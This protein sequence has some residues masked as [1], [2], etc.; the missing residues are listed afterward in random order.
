MTTALVERDATLP[1][2]PDAFVPSETLDALRGILPRRDELAACS[3]EALVSMGT[4][5]VE[6]EAR[7]RLILG[8]CAL[9]VGSR[10]GASA[11]QRKA[12]V[13]KFCLDLGGYPSRQ[14]AENVRIARFIAPEDLERYP[15][16]SI[17]HF[18]AATH[19]TARDGEALD[20]DA[21]RERVT[22]AL[23][24]AQDEHLTP[25]A[26]RQRLEAERERDERRLSANEVDQTHGF[27]AE[28]RQPDLPAP[29]GDLMARVQRLEQLMSPDALTSGLEQRL[30]REEPGTWP[31]IVATVREHL[32]AKVGGA[33]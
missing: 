31:L 18:W 19:L 33:A 17:T 21:R 4:E 8:V 28:P 22:Q 11:S 29:D 30:R 23:Q 3:Y 15:D 27:I 26:L 2:D 14:M 16:L 6:N 1:R 10:A 20:A 5:L 25:S 32:A 13:D 24:S 7:A 12:L 9:E